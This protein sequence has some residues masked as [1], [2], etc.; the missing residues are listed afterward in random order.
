MAA[1]LRGRR[2]FAAV[3][4]FSLVALV[5]VLPAGAG[6]PGG[7]AV[8]PIVGYWNLSGGVVQVT[9]SGSAFTGKVVKATRFSECNHPAGELIWRITKSGTGYTG[10]HQ[11]FA[12]GAPECAPGGAANR[13]A[14]TWSITESGT[15]LRLHFCTT[16]PN[17]SGDTRCNDLTRAKPPSNPPVVK[18][19]PT[20]LT[21]PGTRG[22]LEFTVKDDSGKAKAHL[23]LYE[24]GRALY[25]ADSSLGAAEGKVWAYNARFDAN[26][27]GPLYFCVWAEN[28][29]GVKSR[30]APGSSCN[31]I[32]LLAPLAKVSNGC[33]GAGWSAI[34]WVQNY[35]GNKHTY[36]DSN[37]NPLARSYTVDFAPAC[38]IHDAG[39]GGQTIVDGINGGTV[40]FH[41]WSRKQVDD[42]FL[43]DMQTLCARAIPA[44][45]RTALANCRARG[46]NISLGAR[47]LYNFV[48][49]QGYRFFDADLTK[50]GLQRSGHR[51]NA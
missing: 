4:A 35:F 44:T 27:I 26:L 41:G 16:N 42:K 19:K 32:S 28:A 8:D 46:G 15:S 21:R 45:A 51:G 10:T 38:N 34:V 36:K 30:N 18:A 14:A 6:A 20:G 9:G 24:G 50:T 7:R 39:Y 22:K 33:G 49:S 31:W 5:T 25:T 43:A 12:S 1:R 3:A 2:P 11:W 17:S 48:R 40:D 37:I 23:T 47:S 29:A 13:G